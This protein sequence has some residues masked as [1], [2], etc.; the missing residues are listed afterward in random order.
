MIE[1]EVESS[2]DI[3]S[4]NFHGLIERNETIQHHYLGA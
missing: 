2:L 3:L 1:K 4:Y